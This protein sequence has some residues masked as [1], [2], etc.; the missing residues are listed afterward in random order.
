M[1]KLGDEMKSEI[2]YALF[3]LALGVSL[4][5]YAHQTFATK[6]EVMDIKGTLK[7]IDNR[8]YDLH[9]YLMPKKE[10]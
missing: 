2:R 8:I 7:T 1:A 5:V 9:R 3:I 10:N 4:T 6:S